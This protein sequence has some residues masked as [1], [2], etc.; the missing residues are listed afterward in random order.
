MANKLYRWRIFLRSTPPTELGSV[1]AHDA[2]EAISIAIQEFEIEPAKR[3]RLIAQ[4]TVR[5]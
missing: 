1:E 5:T 3:K 2:E 4:R